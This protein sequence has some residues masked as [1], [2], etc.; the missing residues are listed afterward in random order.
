[1]RSI[2]LSEFGLFGK[3]SLIPPGVALG[4]S[5]SCKGWLWRRSSKDSGAEEEL[6]ECIELA[7][8]ENDVEGGIVRAEAVFD[9][10]GDKRMIEDS[11]VRGF[12]LIIAPGDLA[13]GADFFLEFHDREE[14]V[15]VEAEPSIESV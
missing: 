9:L 11:S 6:L 13:S 3:G 1:M 15:V 14:E 2:L 7:F 12:G 8:E 4:R 10:L 5:V